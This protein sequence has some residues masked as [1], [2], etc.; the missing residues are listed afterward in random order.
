MS[1]G[2]TTLFAATQANATSGNS[3]ALDEVDSPPNCTSTASASPAAKWETVVVL[4]V[5][6]SRLDVST[7]MANVM[8][9]TRYAYDV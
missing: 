5:S 9:K 1:F 6:F 7:N 4:A 3:F 8:G 2:L